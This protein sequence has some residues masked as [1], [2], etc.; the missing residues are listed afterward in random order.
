[1]AEADLKI[2]AIRAEVR[3]LESDLAGKDVT[4]NILGAQVKKL[5]EA[6]QARANESAQRSY[7]AQAMLTCPPNVL[8][9]M[10]NA[11]E[12]ELQPN[13]R[14]TSAALCMAGARAISRSPQRR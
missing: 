11:L 14:S 4:I 6:L 2:S 10:H 12:A 5:E 8:D 9:T 1:M 3:G 7:M 13:P